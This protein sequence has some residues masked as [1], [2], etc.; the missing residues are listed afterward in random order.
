LQDP[1]PAIKYA[2]AFSW[3]ELAGEG[4]FAGLADVINTSHGT[5]LDAILRGFFHGLNYI[6]LDASTTKNVEQLVRAFEQALLDVLPE[7]RISATLSLAWIQHPLAGDVLYAGFA[8]ET[9]PNVKAQMLRTAVNFSSL[10]ATKL[11]SDAL[12]D[13][14]ELVRQTGEYLQQHDSPRI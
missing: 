1:N 2:A 9:D 8:R 13:T 10:V 3:V 6:G 7:A 5:E 12:T 4:S 11:L 14:V